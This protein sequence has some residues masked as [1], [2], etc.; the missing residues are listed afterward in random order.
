M[1]LRT[2]QLELA[3]PNSSLG[4]QLERGYRIVLYTLL[5]GSENKA[6]GE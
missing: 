2:R 1:Q 4:A 3:F 5:A 6:I